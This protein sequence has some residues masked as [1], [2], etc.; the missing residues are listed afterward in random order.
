MRR[1][2]AVSSLLVLLLSA[3]GAP[4][5]GSV[6]TDT[7][8]PA[9]AAPVADAHAGEIDWR[10]GDVLAA[11]SEAAD[12][13][14]PILLYWGAEWCPPCHRLRA[15][16][17][18]DPEFIARTR[19]FVAVYLDG[20]TEGAQRWGDHFQIQGYP[21]IILL[22]PDQAEIT[23]L[24]GGEEP[25]EI[26]KALAAAQESQM[27]AADL[28][29][30]AR[31]N[32]AQL[33]SNDWALLAAYGWE[34]DGT[35]LVPLEERAALFNNLAAAAPDA[36][37]QR[38]FALLA[39]EADV[40]NEAPGYDATRQSEIRTMLATLLASADE[41]KRN[42]WALMYST[43]AIIE[44]AG[45]TPEERKALESALV[46][47][48]DEL[49]ND[50]S[51][52][53]VDRVLTLK[54]ELDV[55]HLNAGADAAPAPELLEKVRI[56]AAWADTTA[57]TPQE[58]QSAIYYAAGLLQDAGDLDG[59]EQLFA[60][61]L[62]RSATPYYYMPDLADI[63]EAR[64][65][66]TGALE[67][68]RKGYEESMGPA[69]RAQWGILYVEGVMRLT[70]EDVAGLEAAATRIIDELAQPDSYHQRT[71][72]RFDR[73]GTTLTEWSADNAEA[74]AVLGRLRTHMHEVCAPAQSEEE[75][76][77]ACTAWLGEA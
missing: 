61:E 37:L 64:G 63:A 23:R 54:A 7:P 69:T 66:K 42:R 12:S 39:L 70:P 76:R 17:F 26:A 45:G 8:A 31:E 22:S 3:C 71:R 33:A 59:A 62:A 10:K 40:N 65:D 15:G 34:V 20:D 56:R 73:L 1:N 58:R 53:L 51:L 16:L 24:S 9:A 60:A 19:D 4:E 2:P 5:Q 48:L 6:A 57:Q 11:F 29:R 30:R 50:E 27:S 36:A 55:H 18:M 47:A 25:D 38:R 21:T 67:W 49:F 68:L 52:P 35:A 28:F 13:S 77:A 74:Q 46:A 75:A 41:V 32:P 44:R 72:V 14:K 43:A